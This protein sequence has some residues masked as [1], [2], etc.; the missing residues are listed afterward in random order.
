MT[1]LCTDR[2]QAAAIRR[3]LRRLPPLSG[4]PIRIENTPG[5]R[6]RRGPVHAGSCL[7]KRRIAFDCTR[8]EFPRIFVHELFHFV[9]LHAGNPLRRSYEDLLRAE[10]AA[11]AA[12]ELGWS[13]EWR[14]QGISLAHIRARSRRWRDYCC[15][16]FCDTAAWLYSG[17]RRHPEFNLSRGFRRL[18]R[19][20]F[21]KAVAN[22]ELPV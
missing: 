5:L 16:S 7:R 4:A 9:W 15:E 3:L 14:R 17:V 12:S 13:A 21:Q 22:R 10:Y 18:R 6:D 1:F 8:D 20:W 2:S 11:G 19:R